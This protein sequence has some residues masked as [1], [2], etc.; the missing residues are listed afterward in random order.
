MQLVPCVRFMEISTNEFQL[1]AM[2]SAKM[3]EIVL[4]RT[5]VSV[6]MGIVAHTVQ[7]VS[8]LM[9]ISDFTANCT[10]PCENNG[11]CVAKDSNLFCFKI[12]ACDCRGTGF[13]GAQCE[14]A[15]CDPPCKAGICGNPDTC[16]CSGT[17]WTGVLCEIRILFSKLTSSHMQ[18]TL[19]E[20]CLWTFSKCV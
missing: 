4:P 7:F 11:T 20:W 9:I 6:K 2:L 16:D 12:G 18:S 19:C 8:Y 17:G 10:L 13:S 15:V 14:V 3:V 5:F 1:F